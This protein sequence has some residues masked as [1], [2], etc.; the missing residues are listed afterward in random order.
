MKEMQNL[1]TEPVG[2]LLA[3]YA[4]PSIIALLVGSLYNIVD[5][6][7]I[8]QCIGKLG[9]AATTVAY[10]F[11]T[12]SLTIS[13]LFGVGMSVYY[14]TELGKNQPQKAIKGAGCALVAMMI[15]AVVFVV[16]SLTF[17]NPIIDAFGAT[18]ANRPYALEY[19]YIVL[20][21]MLLLIFDTA[22]ANLVRA[23]GSPQFSMLASLA[24][25]LVNCV[26]DPVFLFVF[27]WG[28]AGAA[29]ATV[30][31]QVV[32]TLLYFWR[33]FHMKN[34]KFR[35][36]DFAMHKESLIAV[37]RFGASA[38]L[39][40]I[41]TLAVQV[42]MNN[43]LRKYGAA[44]IYGADTAIACMGVAM[45]LQ[46]I[47]IS[48]V[49]GLSQAMQPLV[50]FNYGAKE[51]KRVMRFLQD[52]VLSSFIAGFIITLLFQWKAGMILSWFG[53]GDELYQQF[54]QHVLRVYMLGISVQ[55]FQILSSAYFSTIGQMVKG[56][57]LSLTRTIIF[58]VPIVL[59]LANLFGVEGLLFA[60]P[61]CDVI[62]AIISVI[63][64]FFS[65]K[66]LG[67]MAQE[68]VQTA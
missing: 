61:L 55:G 27:Q 51:Y 63:F 13:L 46:G 47:Y 66:T 19:C 57:F 62:S 28:M 59:L 16:V 44:S 10:P 3:G 9:N 35:K 52:A 8:G 11:T 43:L 53:N 54:G 1:R 7:F 45:K 37:I 41:A 65:F 64:V 38:S 23:D 39:N 6:I 32:T 14:S 2:K 30:L 49:V 31:G 36:S 4:I 12:I 33:F 68:S 67:Q 26:L 17:L 22:F 60:Q 34:G 24:G 20:P 29:W 15:V 42:L 5:Q 56:I 48:A 18:E 40:Q 25:A 58:F 21:G 50:G